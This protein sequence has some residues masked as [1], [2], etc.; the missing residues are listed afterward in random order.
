MLVVRG[1]PLQPLPKLSSE[2]RLSLD[3]WIDPRSVGQTTV[4]RPD[5]GPWS[6]SMDLGPLYPAS[7]ANDNRPA[8]T[9]VRSTI[10]SKSLSGR[11]DL[12]PQPTD[13]RLTYGP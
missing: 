4:H 6:M 2:N 5:H 13:H 3:P 9:V 11:L 7:N 12:R 8:R 1:S 10:R